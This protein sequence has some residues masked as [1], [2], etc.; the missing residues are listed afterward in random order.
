MA[1]PGRSKPAGIAERTELQGKA[2]LV[3]TAAAALDSRKIGSSQGP[4]ADE[5]GFDRPEGQAGSQAAHR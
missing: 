4:M 5:V 3:V 2:E 1:S